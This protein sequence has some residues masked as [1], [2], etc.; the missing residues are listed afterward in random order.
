MVRLVHVRGNWFRCVGCPPLTTQKEHAALI[1]NYAILLTGLAS[2]GNRYVY[3]HA[4]APGGNILVRPN[5]LIRIDLLP[6][7]STSSFRSASQLPITKKN[8]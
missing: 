3:P 8:L 2:V 7:L 6:A 5:M 1:A 4:P